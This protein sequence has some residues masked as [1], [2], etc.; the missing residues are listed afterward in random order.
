MSACDRCKAQLGLLQGNMLV[1]SRLQKEGLTFTESIRLVRL[2]LCFSLR[3]RSW[4]PG[5]PTLCVLLY[6]SAE[7]LAKRCVWT[8]LNTAETILLRRSILIV[9]PTLHSLV[10][11]SS[12]TALGCRGAADHSRLWGSAEIRVESS[13]AAK[14]LS[15]A[16]NYCCHVPSDSI[17]GGTG[18]T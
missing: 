17:I 12:P 10:L 9:Y 8:S 4:F 5:K 3:W 1:Q 2:D 7:R 11:F 13:H 18:I 15:V 16:S 6:P 14:M